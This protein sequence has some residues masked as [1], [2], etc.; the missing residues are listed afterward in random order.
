MILSNYCSARELEKVPLRV[1]KSIFR[2]GVNKKGFPLTPFSIL[3][4]LNY[5]KFANFFHFFSMNLVQSGL[6]F[7]ERISAGFASYE[8]FLGGFWFFF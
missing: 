5:E 6:R 7:V 3:D 2:E 4:L 1:L 8:H